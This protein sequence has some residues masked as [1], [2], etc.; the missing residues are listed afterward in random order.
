VSLGKGGG[1][2]QLEDVATGEAAIPVEVV[3][4]GR[5]NGRE[6]LQTSHLAEAL[7]GSCPSSKG[8]VRISCPIVQPAAGFHS[9]HASLFDLYCKQWPEPMPPIPHS[10]M[11]DIDAALM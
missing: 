11:A 8:Q 7:H 1:S 10:F 6:L 4:Y 9:G 2:V 5:V 3:E